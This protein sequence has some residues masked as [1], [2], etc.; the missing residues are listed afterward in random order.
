MPDHK[1][2]TIVVPVDVDEGVVDLVLYLNTIPGIRTH[3]S[4]QGTIG[5]GGAHPYGPHAMVTW[6]SEAAFERLKSAFDLSK[7]SIRGS[8]CYVH[9]R[10]DIGHRI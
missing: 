4:C 1:Q 7:V 5:E 8:W 2:I 6:A 3:A 10:A 9:P